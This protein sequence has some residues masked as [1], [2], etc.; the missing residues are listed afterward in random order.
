Y[1]LDS[2][3][4]EFNFQAVRL[5]RDVREI[6]GR[7]L[8]IAGNV[9]PVGKR[10]DWANPLEAAA[11]EETFREQIGVLWEAGADLLLFETFS[12]IIELE[13]AVRAA[14]EL[15]DLPIVASTT[16]AEDGR[17][18]AG[19]SPGE[20]AKRLAEAG[21]DVL[22]INCSVGPAKMLE[23][24]EAMRQAAPNAILSAMPNAGF[25]RRVDG[26]FYYPSS[27]EYF[28][29]HVTQFV[30]AG[31]Q[32]V[33][34][35]CGTTPMH[36]RAMRMTLDAHL[37]RQTAAIS[38]V[39]EAREELPQLRVGEDG[40]FQLEDGNQPTELLRKLA[41][42]KFVISVEV[43]PPRSFTAE[44]QIEGAR[45]AKAMGADVINV[46]DSPMARV[47]MGALALCTLIQ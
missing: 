42:G 13:V 47:R 37:A 30:K 41:A 31:A 21:V 39:S 17:T 8:F 44:K 28:A 16:Y 22:G 45:T 12:D 29:D 24:L 3:V 10:V 25:P 27:P 43:D 15:C 46:A 2:K 11:V 4:R 33:G 26:R 40:D 5:V 36:I 23:T 7:A 1:G 18:L 34:G 38:G 6:A 35:C 20:V 19:H 9:G 14:R 32:L